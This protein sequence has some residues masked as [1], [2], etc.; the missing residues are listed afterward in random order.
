M[1]ETNKPKTWLD[2]YERL[3]DNILRIL[4]LIL[5]VTWIAG[6]HKLVIQ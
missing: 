3:I 6:E 4:W 2:K 1:V 5:L